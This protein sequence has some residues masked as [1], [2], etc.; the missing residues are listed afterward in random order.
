MEL[1]GKIGVIAC[2]GMDKAVGSVACLSAFKVCENLRPD[3]TELICLPPFLTGVSPYPELVKNLPIIAIDGCAQR[4]S[5]KLI[6][7]NGGKIKGRI[8]VSDISKKQNLTLGPAS[9][10]GANGVKLAEIVAQEIVNII[11]KVGES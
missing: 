4:C 8:L 10:I 2:A 5:T 3:E 6:V 11:D 9:N 1:K 7:K